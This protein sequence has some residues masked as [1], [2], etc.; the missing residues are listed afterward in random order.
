[1]QRIAVSRLFAA[2]AVLLG[3]LAV[4]WLAACSSSTPP[5][6]SLGSGTPA[7]VAASGT[8]AGPG[9]T[10]QVGSAAPGASASPGPDASQQP[11]ASPAPTPTPRPTPTP[12]TAPASGP[13]D[14]LRLH[15]V[16][17]ITGG[18]TPK[19]VDASQTGLFF[20]QNMIYGHNIRVFDRSYNLVATIR[21]RINLSR[22]G[23]PEYP[24]PVRG[25]PVE[26]A[27]SKDKST[28]YVSNYSMFG[29]GFNHP[30][31]DDCRPGEGIDRS[32]I[33][34]IDVAGF[35]VD[36]ALR[37]G[38][39]PK[40]L[41][42]TPKGKTLVVSNWCSGSISIVDLATFTV[43]D[44]VNVGWHP[45]GIVF[46]KRSKLAY[47]AVWDLNA[48]AVVD[49]ATKAVRH[50]PVGLN[51]RHLA[52]D[53]AGR[54]LYV[55][56]NGAGKIAKLDLKT[57]TVVATAATGKEPRSMVIAQDGKS[58][59]VVNYS[60]ATISKVRTRDMH[61]LQTIHVGHHPIGITYDNATRN[62]WVAIYSGALD[63]FN[64][65]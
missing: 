40:F 39:V 5:D 59:Y 30:G 15:L 50:I 9:S 58:L 53:P 32:F 63:V 42:V 57:E 1:M 41:A 11:S 60:S 4:A 18:L 16:R 22:F 34:R 29:P 10:G 43:T 37:V 13:S 31:R 17:S 23:Y 35:R 61:V 45:R 26:A 20:A 46:D 28:V 19:S 33:Y 25:G 36:A 47:V 49:L 64:D 48:V 62:V 65:R 56:L 7:A 8:A 12:T 14:S 21:D 2:A 27:F 54:Y 51:P 55:S 3:L 44:V 38:Q 6:A 52:M 24:S